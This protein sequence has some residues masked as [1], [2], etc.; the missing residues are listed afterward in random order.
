MPTLGQIGEY[1]EGASWEEY[2]EILSNYFGSNGTSDAEKKRQI[3]LSAVGPKT[4]HLIA[5]LTAPD[6]PSAK[7]YTALA[8]LVNNHLNPAPSSIVS[9]FK[10]YTVKRKAG[11]SIA[12]FVMNLRQA[13]TTCKFTDINELLRDIF[14][15]GINNDSIQTKLLSIDDSITFNAA[16]EIALS[17]EAAESNAKD[18]QEASASIKAS[19]NQKV[20]KIN[21]KPWPSSPW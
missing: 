7:S 21:S 8:T 1:Q 12:S 20:N 11:E 13:A 19:P 14:I 9:G 6:K 5:K 4:Y 3:L 10:F 16:V 17:M 15:V 2:T 18:I